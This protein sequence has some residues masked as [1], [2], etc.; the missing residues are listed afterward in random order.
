MGF[1]CVSGIY[2]HSQ[3]DLWKDPG[4]SLWYKQRGN[5][6]DKEAHSLFAFTT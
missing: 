2:Q 1:F 3:G 6:Y 4:G 5:P